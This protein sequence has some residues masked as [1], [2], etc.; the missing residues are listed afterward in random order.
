TYARQLGRAFFLRNKAENATVLGFLCWVS[1]LHYGPNRRHYPY[2]RFE[3]DPRGDVSY[4]Y[5]LTVRASIYAWAS[6]FV[7][8]RI[9]RYIF[10]RVY[11]QNISE[12]AVHDFH[13]Y[14]HVVPALVLVTI[15]VLQNILFA[16]IHLDFQ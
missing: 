16:M 8:S 2:F 13:R 4:E 1:V 14:P 9:V 6:E 12:D 5:S 3:H 11:A 15:H 10:R 7:A